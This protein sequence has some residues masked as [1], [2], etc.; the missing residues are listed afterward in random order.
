MAYYYKANVHWTT[1][2]HIDEAWDEEDVNN[3]GLYFITRRYFRNGEEVERPLYVGI[4]TRNFYTRLNEH[5][6]NNAKWAQSYGRKYI[7]FGTVSIYRQDLYDLFDLLTEIET[8]IIQELDMKYP[9][10]LLNKQQKRSHS[11]RYDLLI[12]HFNNEWLMD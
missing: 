6:K 3:N 4:T 8:D 1:A 12:T 2:F 5:Y 9:D 7:R 10:E 11:D